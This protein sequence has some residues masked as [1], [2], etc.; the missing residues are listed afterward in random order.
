MPHSAAQRK[1]PAVR[2]FFK[3]QGQIGEATGSKANSGILPP[4]H[5]Q[6]K[7]LPTLRSGKL[8]RRL[9]RGFPGEKRKATTAPQHG[10]LDVC[11]DLAGQ[12]NLQRPVAIAKRV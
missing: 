2:G 8:R 10:P 6:V 7:H 3:A 4:W 5:G 12:L 11:D 1:S 9:R